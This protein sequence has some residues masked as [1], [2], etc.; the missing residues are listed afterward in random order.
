MTDTEFYERQAVVAEAMTWLGTPFHHHQ[1]VK[2]AGVD[3]ALFQYSVYH[4]VGLIPEIKIEDYSPQWHLHKDE[5][6]YMN[7][8]LQFAARVESAPFKPG[9]GALFRFGRAASHGVIIVEWPQVI[10]AYSKSRM[11]TLDNALD[12]PSLAFDRAGKSRREGI[13]RLKQWA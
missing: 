4:G 1:A 8:V 11:V 2:G 10:H 7:W 9:D 12:N 13:F 6:R 5:E 3:C